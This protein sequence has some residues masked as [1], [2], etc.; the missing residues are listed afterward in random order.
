MAGERLPMVTV[1]GPLPPGLE[2]MLR[3]DG[4]RL[5]DLSIYEHQG[6]EFRLWYV[7]NPDA[8]FA[9]SFS[10]TSLHQVRPARHPGPIRPVH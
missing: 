1:L 10:L 9:S 7:R 8:W 6:Q 5:L 3:L 2:Q 4:R